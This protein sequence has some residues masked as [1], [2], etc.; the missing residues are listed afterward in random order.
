VSAWPPDD[1][2][3]SWTVDT[4]C[5]FLEVTFNDAANW[6]FSCVHPVEPSAELVVQLDCFFTSCELAI[7]PGDS[8]HVETFV[9]ITGP[10]RNRVSE[11]WT[12][13]RD[14]EGQLLLIGVGARSVEF[15]GGPDVTAPLSFELAPPGSCEPTFECA[16]HEPVPIF[17]ASGRESVVVHDSSDSTI[18]VGGASYEVS[19]Q[20]SCRGLGGDDSYTARFLLLPTP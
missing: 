17:V 2:G 9:S 11:I 13:L 10:R 16:D 19:V 4:G 12:V 6:H 15:P 8:V 5:T 1:G 14:A 20:T 18:E 7:A 3:T